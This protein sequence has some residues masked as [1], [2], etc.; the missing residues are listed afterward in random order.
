MFW[1]MKWWI[2]C[3]KSFESL[4]MYDLRIFRMNSQKKFWLGTWY[5]YHSTQHQKLYV[6]SFT[7]LQSIGKAW[8]GGWPL[9]KIRVEHWFWRLHWTVGLNG[10]HQVWD[11]IRNL[12]NLVSVVTPDPPDQLPRRIIVFRISSERILFGYYINC[13]EDISVYLFASFADIFRIFDLSFWGYLRTFDRHLY[14]YFS[15]TSIN[16]CDDCV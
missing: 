9:L 7:F 15:N 4:D 8:H 2:C 10:V 12:C 5:G 6:S 13:F 1:Y 16:F 11:L 3:W 14:G